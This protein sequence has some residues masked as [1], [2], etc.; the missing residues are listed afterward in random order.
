MSEPNPSTGYVM[1]H[2][3]RERR[4][5]TLQASIINPYTE[6]LLM[7][8]GISPGMHVLDIGCGVGEVSMGTPDRRL[9]PPP[10]TILQFGDP[11]C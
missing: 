6:R 5:L 7:R 2:D 8:A 11:V 9:S 3:E 4:R 10:F 1:G